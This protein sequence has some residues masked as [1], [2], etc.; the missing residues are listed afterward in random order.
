MANRTTRH[1]KRVS[2]KSK[3]RTRRTKRRGGDW[4][5]ISSI[6]SIPSIPNLGVKDTISGVK[7]SISGKFPSGLFKD[8]QKLVFNGEITDQFNM[9]NGAARKMIGK[10]I[11]TIQV[12][13][14]EVTWTYQS[15]VIT[16][17]GK[18]FSKVSSS[19]P[20][21]GK[22]IDGLINI[23]SGKITKDN[24]TGIRGLPTKV[25]LTYDKIVINDDITINIENNTTEEFKAS[26][27]KYY[28]S[29]DKPNDD[30]KLVTNSNNDV[31]DNETDNAPNM[32]MVR[33]PAS[34]NLLDLNAI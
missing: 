17:I 5:N 28:K 25:V 24:L 33:M 27:V 26:I 18:A 6:S 10:T 30:A 2:K 7:E 13:G 1:K 21:V 22:L 19:N 3:R 29:F 8:N 34:N 9:L 12:Q 14:D 16:G 11:Y 4:P 15:G 32:S 23:Y 31:A 20:L